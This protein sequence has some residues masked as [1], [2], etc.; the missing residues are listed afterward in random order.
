M[1]TSRF[2]TAKKVPRKFLGKF[3]KFSGHNLNG[4]EVIQLFNEGRPQYPISKLPQQT[5]CELSKRFG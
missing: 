3:A 4:F 1:Q 2:T 5:F